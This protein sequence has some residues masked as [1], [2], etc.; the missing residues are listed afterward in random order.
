[1]SDRTA[2]SGE[3]GSI[4]AFPR[5]ASTWALFLDVDGTLLEI[6]PSPDRVRVPEALGTRLDELRALLADALALVSGRAIRD[7]DGLFAP[8]RF[9]AAGVHGAEWRIGERIRTVDADPARLDPARRAFQDFTAAHAGT[10]WED[11]RYAVTLHYRERPDLSADA[12]AVARDAVHHLKGEGAVLE[13]K[14]VLEVR[15][16]QATKA[17]AV[18]ALMAEPPFA[19]RVP[20]YLGDDVTDEDAFAAVNRLGG[21]SIAV[22]DRP[23]TTASH[24]LESVP[25]VHR[26]IDALARHLQSWA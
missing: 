20:V 16:R 19:G 4:P 10:L 9:S 24:N 18:A 1:V 8:H 13:G 14:M 7:L 17:A 11:K 23:G 3:R 15:F 22:G 12:R 2:P 25:A 26:W 6:A 5:D 21:I